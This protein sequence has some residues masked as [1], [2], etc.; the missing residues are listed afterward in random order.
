MPNGD[1]PAGKPLGDES[2]ADLSEGKKVTEE[3]LK[4][5]ISAFYKKSISGKDL[6]LYLNEHCL[7]AGTKPV[8]N[9][10]YLLKENSFSEVRFTFSD[11]LHI[12][13][14]QPFILRIASIVRK[15]LS[16]SPESEN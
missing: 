14:Y 9:I 3:E 1:E 12:I 7:P 15:A 4:K 2:S 13:I 6:D 16:K 8:S 10:N 5:Y 11:F